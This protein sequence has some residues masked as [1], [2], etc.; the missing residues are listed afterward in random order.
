GH[1]LEAGAR[2]EEGKFAA[3][4]FAGAGPQDELLG[5]GGRFERREVAAKAVGEADRGKCSQRG[6]ERFERAPG[7]A[8]GEIAGA[9]E[10]HV[11]ESTVQRRP[12][13]LKVWRTYCAWISTT[14]S[15]W[16]TSRMR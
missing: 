2:I 3:E 16:T 7:G 4:P 12:A 5:E 1:H 6:I 11:C 9:F 13:M 8:R 15:C 14:R 10:V